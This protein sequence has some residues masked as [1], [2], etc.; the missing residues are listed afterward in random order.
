LVN[1]KKAVGVDE[2]R[3]TTGNSSLLLLLFLPLLLLLIMVIFVYRKRSFLSGCR[4]IAVTGVVDVVDR[5]GTLHEQTP[6]EGLVAWTPA[7]PSL[8]CCCCSCR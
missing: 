1:N 6:F 4:D 7:T 5:A 3:P 8:C 2:I